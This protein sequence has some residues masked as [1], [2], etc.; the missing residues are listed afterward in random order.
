MGGARVIGIDPERVNVLSCSGS[1]GSFANVGNKERCS[2]TQRA[3]FRE[4]GLRDWRGSEGLMEEMGRC[5]L[6]TTSPTLFQSRLYRL[7]GILY[8]TG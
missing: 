4:E 3:K 2:W 1:D 5:S 8:W 6:K 7:C